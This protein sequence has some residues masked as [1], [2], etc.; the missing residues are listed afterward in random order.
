VTVPVSMTV[1]G[2]S[3]S[4]EI[5]SRTLLVEL[6]REELGLTGCGAQ[7]RS[8]SCNTE[9]KHSATSWVCTSLSRVPVNDAILGYGSA[10]FGG[11]IASFLMVFLM[12]EMELI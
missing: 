4:A 11:G 9:Y 2:E 8:G 3:V 1:N 7:R 6:L 5:D 12:W 10:T